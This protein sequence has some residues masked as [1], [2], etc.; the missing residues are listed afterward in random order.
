MLGVVSIGMYE[1]A[2]KIILAEQLPQHR[3]LIVFAG[4]VAGLADR[5][6]QSVLI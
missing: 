2:L 3:L 5:H 6:T 1:N 4:G